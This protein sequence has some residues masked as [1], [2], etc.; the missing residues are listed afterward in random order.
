MYVPKYVELRKLVV[1]E[2]YRVPYAVHPRYPKNIAVVTN[3]YFW[4]WMQKYIIECIAKCMECQNL[5]VEKKHPT[6][7]L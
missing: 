7:F 1:N 3:Q 2:M 5:K 6:S 4:P